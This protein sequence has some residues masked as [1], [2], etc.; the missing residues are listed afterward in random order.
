MAQYTVCVL[1]F[2]FPVTST[3][4]SHPT[5]THHKDVES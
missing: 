2:D 4:L 3:D 1:I 5:T